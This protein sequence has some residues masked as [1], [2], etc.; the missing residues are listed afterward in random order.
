MS[1]FILALDQG[2]T[3]SRAIV[4]DESSRI[5]SSAQREF[6][7]IFPEA[8]WV[9]HDPEA[10]WQTQLA[11]A[12]DAIRDAR[13]SATD[14]TAIGITNQRETVVIWDRR[15]GRPIHNAIVW[16]DRRTAAQTDALKDPASAKRI[17]EQTGLL[18]DPYFSASKVRWLLDNVAGAHEAAHDGHL[19]LGTID[20]WLVYRLTEGSAHCTD[21]SNASRTM[22]FN[23]HSAAWDDALLELFDIPRSM[24]PEV[25]HS[26][27]VVGATAKAL[28]GAEVPIAGIAG[29]QQ[30]ALFG[31][32]CL[33][34]GMVKNT[35]GTGCFMLT[36]TG[37]QPVMSQSRLLTTVAWRLAGQPMQYALEG[38]V[39]IGGA[40]IQWLRDGL[41]IIDSAA[42]VNALAA[43]VEDSGGVIVVP[44][45]VGLGA[46][47]W[48]PR[49]RG[50]MFGLTRG[51]TAAHIARATLDGIAF[52]VADVLEA[53]E[54]D[55]GGR[56]ANLRVDGGAAA[57]DLLM[58][59]QADI[60]GIEV[61]RPCVTETTALGAAYLAGLG[62]GLWESPA[63]LESRW[64]PDRVFHVT[65]EASGRQ[66]R[67]AE[68]A[69]AI[70]RAKVWVD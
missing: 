69:R 33:E 32:L 67:R 46:P 35:Y 8:G 38:S 12:R 30:A 9:E 28:L 37:D 68:W 4:F 42:E 59:M 27:G 53:M 10:I 52:Q 65:T 24:L 34:P 56:L 51:T 48:D 29:D 40:A 50:A 45:F 22:L 23:I 57:S 60:A 31:Q 19:A 58:Q 17:R 66:R 63:A 54:C 61:Q 11:T 70:E 13:L 44:A 21:V 16:Q 14:I 47:H 25:V 1:A 26:S 43:S 20:S 39:F 49:A 41:G 15:T 36:Q 18:P 6:E 3:S 64:Q 7:Q 62:V 2:T 55:M 5:V